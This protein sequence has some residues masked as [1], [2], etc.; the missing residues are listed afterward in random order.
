VWA[1][2]SC[3]CLAIWRQPQPWEG[4]D[5]RAGM[6]G[7]EGDCLLWLQ[8]Q[9]LS[10]IFKNSNLNRVSSAWARCQREKNFLNPP[11]SSL[12]IKDDYQVNAQ[13]GA[14]ALTK[15]RHR[16]GLWPCSGCQC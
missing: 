16:K 12:K 3:I 9:H 1:F 14:M 13:E 11:K 5:V 4:G 6:E 7:I 8:S 15:L 2:L 10:L